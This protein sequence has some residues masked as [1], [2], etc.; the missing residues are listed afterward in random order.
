MT[1]NLG[2]SG[3]I[4]IASHIW[5]KPNNVVKMEKTNAPIPISFTHRG[6]FHAVINIAMRKTEITTILPNPPSRN[7]EDIVSVGLSIIS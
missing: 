6:A 2:I 5:R 4:W 7:K 1:E 3:V